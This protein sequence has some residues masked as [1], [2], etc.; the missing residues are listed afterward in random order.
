MKFSAVY[1][2]IEANNQSE[3]KRLITIKAG[4]LDFERVILLCLNKLILSTGLILTKLFCVVFLRFIL[5]FKYYARL[6]WFIICGFNKYLVF[7][8]FLFFYFLF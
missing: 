8:F 5:I 3:V 2:A 1:A 7:Y 6:S 4:D